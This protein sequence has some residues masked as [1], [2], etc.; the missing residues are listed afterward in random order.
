VIW[1][2]NLDWLY[3]S[4]YEMMRSIIITTKCGSNTHKDP[5]GIQRKWFIIIQ[6][7]ERSKSIQIPV[8]SAAAPPTAAGPGAFI[9]GGA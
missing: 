6:F 7:G 9:N 8:A 2:L 3:T 5:H 1:T 4:S